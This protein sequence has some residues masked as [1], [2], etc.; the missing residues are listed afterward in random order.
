M[1]RLVSLIMAVLLLISAVPAEAAVLLSARQ[2]EDQSAGQTVKQAAAAGQA[3][4][5]LLQT[6]AQNLSESGRREDLHTLSFELT[7]DEETDEAES[8]WILENRGEETV[9]TVL[10]LPLCS[11]GVKAGSLELFSDAEAVRT[12][13]E[14]IFVKLVPQSAAVF[15]YRYRTKSP[16]I[17]AGTIAFD[18]TQLVFAEGDQVDRALISVRIR[19]EDVPLVQEIFPFNYRVEDGRISVELFCFKPEPFLKRFWISKETWRNLKG[20]RDYET[21]ESQQFLLAHYREWFRNGFGVSPEDMETK[22]VQQLFA[23]L[24]GQTIDENEP[25]YLQPAWNCYGVLPDNNAV[26]QNVFDWLYIRELMR[27]KQIASAEQFREEKLS[28]LLRQN[29]IKLCLYG[30]GAVLADLFRQFCYNKEPAYYVIELAKEPSLEGVRLYRQHAVESFG[31]VFESTPASEEALLKAE[32]AAYYTRISEK[33]GLLYRTSTLPAGPYDAADLQNYL[34]AVGA[35][36]LIQKRLLDDRDDRLNSAWLEKE[37]KSNYTYRYPMI[38]FGLSSGG[39][40]SRKEL[41]DRLELKFFNVDHEVLLREDPVLS[42]L[43][44]PSIMLYTGRIFLHDGLATF[45]HFHGNSV[46]EPQCLTVFRI[47]T[48]TDTAQALQKARSK[49]MEEEQSAVR[50]KL[51]AFDSAVTAETL[52][53]ETGDKA[54]LRVLSFRLE[55]DEESSRVNSELIWENTG[56]EPVSACLSLPL[57]TGRIR[58][59]T[60]SPTVPSG[61]RA[62]AGHKVFFT[63]EAGEML[64]VSYAYQMTASLVHAGTI[65]LDLMSLLPDPA[66][67]VGRFTAAVRLTPE[68]IPLVTEIRPVNYTFDGETVAVE[69][70][71][72]TPNQLLNRFVIVKTTYRQLRSDP[73]QERELS[74]AEKHFFRHYRE[75]FRDGL[76]LDKRRTLPYAG[77][78]EIAEI[79]CRLSPEPG[80]NSITDYPDFYINGLQGSNGSVYIRILHYLLIRELKQLG[81]LQLAEMMIEYNDPESFSLLTQE[82]IRQESFSEEPMIVAVEYASEPTLEGVSLLTTTTFSGSAGPYQPVKERVMIRA[83]VP[84]P[85]TVKWEWN[86]LRVMVIPEYTANEALAPALEAIGASLYIQARLLDNRD[87]KWDHLKIDSPSFPEPIFIGA[88]YFSV[89]PQGILRADELNAA[90]MPNGSNY[91]EGRIFEREEERL[92]ACGVPAFI[93]YCGYVEEKAEG[94][95]ALWFSGGVILNSPL[96][97]INTA[98]ILARDSVAALLEARRINKEQ[99][100]EAVIRKIEAAQP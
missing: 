80:K 63:L 71:D 29:G 32:P 92:A 8:R 44:L 12:A 36:I 97:L 57:L 49:R 38:C 64:K 85:R 88:G 69:L 74:E 50:E 40:I 96:G 13:E 42:A 27:V 20:S 14:K 52:F 37:K 34:D 22:P 58:E 51:A 48:E 15:S 24:M 94:S 28:D 61:C 30:Y 70:I 7:L 87:G 9:E 67:S 2:P 86:N 11:A 91:L 78:G 17:H 46:W 1:K 73:E 45:I 66:S 47:L 5:A 77:L 31:D 93:Q 95:V 68:D 18:F 59:D 19:E 81:Q 55:A 62:V 76:G 90:L 89:L 26:Y 82:L 3:V 75:W 6:A 39:P 72:F 25:L 23:E 21:N 54:A 98:Q 56:T 100:K 10:A 60:F 53:F 35:E 99:T 4:R 16:L 79:L 84:H 41:E 65:G 43:D 33:E 83:G